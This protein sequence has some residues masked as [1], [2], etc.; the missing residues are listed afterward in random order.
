MLIMKIITCHTF[1]ETM[2]C[3]YQR[4]NV[5]CDKIIN[6]RRGNCLACSSVFEWVRKFNSD[7]ETVK[8]AP[9]PEQTN[10]EITGKNNRII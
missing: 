3:L 10:S 8:N 4:R 5:L 7:T 2:N 1:R 9:R 6:Y